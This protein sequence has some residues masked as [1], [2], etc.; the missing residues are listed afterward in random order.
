MTDRDTLEKRGN[1]PEPNRKRDTRS[2][3]LSSQTSRTGLEDSFSAT[4]S[5]D[6]RKQDG[7]AMLTQ[8]FCP[9]TLTVNVFFKQVR[10][11]GY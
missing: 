6:T 11:S 7:A 2:G 3:S 5:R 8:N 1:T 4:D 10:Y 9:V